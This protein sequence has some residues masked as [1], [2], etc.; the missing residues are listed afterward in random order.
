MKQRYRRVKAN[1]QKNASI[2]G[3]RATSLSK[4][5]KKNNRTTTFIREH[6][7]GLCDLESCPQGRHNRTETLEHPTPR[8]TPIRP[9]RKTSPNQSTYVFRRK[10]NFIHKPWSFAGY[11]AAAEVRNGFGRKEAFEWQQRSDNENKSVLFTFKFSL[12]EVCVKQDMIGSL[13]WQVKVELWI[14]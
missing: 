3:L 8:L 10:D 4:K 1:K 7:G 11:A 13:H 9:Q 6:M 12:H 5:K 14:V 2:L